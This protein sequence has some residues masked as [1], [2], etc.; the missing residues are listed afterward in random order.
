MD[1]DT[2]VQGQVQDPAMDTPAPTQTNE[3]DVQVNNEAPEAAVENK[4]STVNVTDTAEEKL[5]AGKYKSPE[6]M[7]KAY[8]ELES[9]FGQTNS[10]KAELSK[11]LNEAFAEPQQQ[12][13]PQEQISDDYEE[14][15][16]LQREVEALKRNQAVSNFVFSHPD[17]DASNMQKVLAE[18]PMIKQISG[19]DAKLEYAFLRSQN[20][21]QAKA[22]AEAQKTA[23]QQTTAKIVE[24]QAAQVEK[25]STSEQ[26][27]ENTELRERATGNYSQADRDAARKAWIRK[28]LVNLS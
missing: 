7:E 3:A 10:E 24:K 15:N 16:P 17:A 13:Q 8:K 18:D 11:I 25:A 28:N 4:E 27:D 1:D 5:Y 14:D 19:H 21:S 9:K 26:T 6:D 22:V 20:M 12:A 2:Q 23:A